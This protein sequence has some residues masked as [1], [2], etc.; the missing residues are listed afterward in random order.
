MAS[1]NWFRLTIA[2]RL[3]VMV[4]VPLIGVAAAF[5]EDIFHFRQELLAAREL[6]TRHVV[7]VAYGVLQ[8]FHEQE[9]AKVLTA[10]QAQDFARQTI[11]KMRYEGVEYMWLNDLGK[12]FPKMVMHPTVP[13]L[14]GTVLDAEKFNKATS[15]RLGSDGA[16]ERFG[17]RNLFVT[18]NQVAE[19]AGHGYVTYDWPK[20]KAGGGATAELYPKLSYVKLFEPWGWVIG[21]G[22]YFDDV[23]TI[24]M[25]TARSKLVNFLGIVAAVGLFGFLV[26]RSITQPLAAVRSTMDSLTAGNKA[27]SIPGTGRHDE[28]G[29]MARALEMFKQ[30]LGKID[31]MR[32]DQ[33]R[34]DRETSVEKRILILKVV[35]EFEK[36]LG[37]MAED[38][39][40]VAATMHDMAVKSAEAT[41]AANAKTRD[42]A[43]E[44]E[45]ASR[46]VGAVADGTQR[47]VASISE[48][49]RDVEQSSRIAGNAMAEAEKTNVQVA[50]LAGAAEK[51]G[52]VVKLITDIAEQTNLL[53][54]N[55]TIEAARAG[56][57]GKGFAVVASE[58]KNLAG[59][60]ARATEEISEQIGGIQE[61]T[62]GA[63][64]QIRR[65]GSVISEINRY[66]GAIS[67]A[68]ADQDKVTK[69]ISHNAER[70][71]ASTTDVSRHADAVLEATELAGSLAQ[72][73]LVSADGMGDKANRMVAEAERFRDQSLAEI[74]AAD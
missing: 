3:G 19:K 52:E 15:L 5:A 37:S 25:A 9:R 46:S 32:E 51:I 57:A 36:K 70:A 50:N 20:P 35:E 29:E 66:S 7:E 6:K 60:T 2:K 65:I 53:A 13:A 72:R 23:D 31:S 59:Q 63:V 17:G 40:M 48:I 42:V 43:N 44:A 27:V 10:A 30:R 73:L 49:A 61:A 62:A 8:H 1:E 64:E 14:D 33:E 71:A 54:L 41:Q 45:A 12:P 58:V 38:V 28:I 18:F 16:V 39:S 21:S 47:L 22:I 74:K 69:D 68:I 24:F 11:K 67:T 34:H 26:A 4:L 55:A 56:D